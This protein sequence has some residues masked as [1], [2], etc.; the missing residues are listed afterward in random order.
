MSV[1]EVIEQIRRMT[2]EEQAL[3]L[4]AVQ[5]LAPA[6]D[7]SRQRGEEALSRLMEGVCTGGGRHLSVGVDDALYGHGA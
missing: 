1:E 6:D 2:P 7:A 4:E 5:G 3:V